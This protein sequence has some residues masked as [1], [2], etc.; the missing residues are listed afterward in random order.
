[1]LSILIELAL[2]INLGSQVGADSISGKASIIEAD[3]M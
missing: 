1:M 3:T 2:L